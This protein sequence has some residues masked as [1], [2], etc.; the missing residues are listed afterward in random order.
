MGSY[1]SG[2][3]TR[4]QLIEAAGELAAQLDFSKVSLRA[5]AKRAG[6]N[7]GCIHYHFKS[8]QKLFEEV[9]RTAT[10]G[11]RDNPYS[12]ILAGFEGELHRPEIQARAIRAIVHRAIS[13][14]FD[15]D[16]PWWHSQVIYQT[17]HARDHLMIFFLSEVINPDMECLKKF[18]KVIKPDL[19]DQ[20][21]F[22]RI[23][24]IKA[25]II[26]HADNVQVICD[27]LGT[28]Q[29]VPEYLKK[30]E[31]LIVLQTRLLLGLPTDEQTVQ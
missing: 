15:P 12:K 13:L 3:Q 25:P 22:L 27:L 8:K 28:D 20:E 2:Q 4:S 16:K 10:Q 1:S 19:D 23:C 17:M 18:F 30:M 11:F 21:A 26:F 31:D 9:I 29:Y 6:Q 5:V 14:T 24:L 7:T